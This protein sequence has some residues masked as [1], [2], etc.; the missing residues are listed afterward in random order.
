[1]LW[2][3]KNNLNNIHFQIF[4]SYPI[5]FAENLQK[6]IDYQTIIKTKNQNKKIQY[7][8]KKLL[9]IYKINRFL[10]NYKLMKNFTSQYNNIKKINIKK[11][12]KKF[13]IKWFTLY[14]NLKPLKLSLTEKKKFKKF[15]IIKQKI[16]YSNKK[17]KKKLV[18]QRYR[19]KR[20]KY[21]TKN[22]QQWGRFRVGK[23]RGSYSKKNFF[24][25]KNFYSKYNLFNLTK[26]IFIRINNKKFYN[27]PRNENFQKKSDYFVFSQSKINYLQ[28]ISN[29][30]IEQSYEFYEKYEKYQKTRWHKRTKL[31][32]KL[33]K[34]KLTKNAKRRIKKRIKRREKKL[35][36]I[37]K[38]RKKF[39]KF[40]RGKKRLWTK[41]RNYRWKR[42]TNIWRNIYC[43][44]KSSSYKH[45]LIFQQNRRSLLHFANIGIKRNFKIFFKSEKQIYDYF[46]FQYTIYL[47]LKKQFKLVMS[48]DEIFNHK[49]LYSK[50]YWISKKRLLILSQDT[51]LRNYDINLKRKFSKKLLKKLERNKISNFYKNRSPRFR[52]RIR[53]KIRKNRVIKAH[54]YDGL[55]NNSWKSRQPIS[56]DIMKFLSSQKKPY[57]R[58]KKK[59]LHSQA[60]QYLT[61]KTNNFFVK[62]KKNNSFSINNYMFLNLESL[63]SYYLK[64]YTKEYKSTV[65]KQ[66]KINKKKIFFFNFSTEKLSTYREAR[67]THWNFFFKKTL[68]GLR[69]QKFLNFFL[70]KTELFFTKIFTYFQ[71]KFN[72]SYQFWVNFNT[73]Y[74]MFFN[75]NS[76]LKVIL[77]FPIHKLFWHFLKEYSLHGIK[78]SIKISDWQ[79][80]K[81]RIKKTFWMQRKVKLPKY[82]KTKNFV[83]NGVTNTIQYDFIT[84]YFIVLKSFNKFEH[85]DC[86]IFKN[87]FLKL[88]GFK[89]NS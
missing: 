2:Q 72:F 77:Q 71:F 84:N 33:F 21:R 80:K 34:V 14:L 36:L 86:F 13:K 24:Q 1:M 54:F 46:K 18:L 57:L 43:W 15:L 87:K 35:I 83:V 73:I 17:K 38:F 9:K 16:R 29:L 26:K 23:L 7:K 65:Q 53:T 61:T 67:K 58:I 76:N 27:V 79:S 59:I 48:R 5:N 8:F 52:I 6:Q 82:L 40:L 45:A 28:Q 49:S 63:E 10:I 30:P 31:L 66:L 56:R 4:Q 55:A 11:F 60:L 3:V 41:L 42:N 78:S 22:W 69:Y 50:P 89:Y 12:S 75:L 85:N 64:F 39:N 70:K 81:L 88:H 51:M 37:D 32:K 47:Q 19:D 44:H 68:K 74:Q 25:R 20:V 62:S